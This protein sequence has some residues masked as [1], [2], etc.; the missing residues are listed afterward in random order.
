MK[1]VDPEA[2]LAAAEAV[3]DPEPDEVPSYY[4]GYSAGRAEVVDAVR[5]YLIAAP[6]ADQRDQLAAAGSIIA[7]LVR[8]LDGY[9]AVVP[10]LPNVSPGQQSAVTRMLAG[11]GLDCNGRRVRT[12]VPM[13]GTVRANTVVVLDSVGSI[14]MSKM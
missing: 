1:L 6:G 7:A 8:Q 9:G 4:H 13:V 3:G 11:V 10:H 12:D 5:A 2:L 14:D